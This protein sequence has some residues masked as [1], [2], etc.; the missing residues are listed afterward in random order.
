MTIEVDNEVD[1]VDD[2]VPYSD[3]RLQLTQEQTR[4]HW[5]HVLDTFCKLEPELVSAPLSE[6][7]DT[8]W[9][10]AAEELQKASTEW[11][12]KFTVDD[13]LRLTHTE[14]D[15]W[16]E[17]EDTD[18]QFPQGLEELVI[19]P[20]GYDAAYPS[21][22]VHS[23]NCPNPDPDWSSSLVVSTDH[24][25]S[26]RWR[27]GPV[28]R[29]SRR[30]AALNNILWSCT[31]N[32]LKLTDEQLKTAKPVFETALTDLL[33][34]DKYRKSFMYDT[35]LNAGLVKALDDVGTKYLK[36]Q[37]ITCESQLLLRNHTAS[38]SKPDLVLPEHVVKPF[39]HDTFKE[40][41][42]YRLS[43]LTERPRRAANVSDIKSAA[44]QIFTWV[45]EELLPTLSKKGDDL[46]ADDYEAL[47]DLTADMVNIL[48]SARNDR[49]NSKTS[50]SA[51][52]VTVENPDSKQ[53]RHGQWHKGSAA[54]VGELTSLR[55][56]SEAG[57]THL[58]CTLTTPREG[59]EDEVWTVGFDLSSYE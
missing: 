37:G 44:K 13:Q 20:R 49:L 3:R 22:W 30:K 14:Q 55:D 1:I 9:P 29:T 24:D 7:S 54:D 53:A 2:S 23:N 12:Q 21:H 35:T 45:D 46:D 11:K 4:A 39:T 33:S 25:E 28:E 16:P 5:R 40:Q 6:S 50:I 47:S 41:A 32:Q 48:S 8:I 10:K 34:N 36:D 26:M 59:K 19:L 38:G 31:T 43:K 52:F 51:A 18:Y 42:E 17:K 57:P 56:E 58:T 15:Q 27:M